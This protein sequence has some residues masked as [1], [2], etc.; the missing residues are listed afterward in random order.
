MIRVG[1]ELPDG[2]EAATIVNAVVRSYMVVNGEYMRGRS[3]TQKTALTASLAQFGN[4]IKQ[5]TA[6][7]N[8]LYAKGSFDASKLERNPD[9]SKNELAPGQPAVSVVRLD[10]SPESV[11][12]LVQ[13]DR[14]YLE[15]VARLE[16]TNMLLSQS[17]D[18]AERKLKHRIAEEFQKVPEVVDIT[19]KLEHEQDQLE[20]IKG[21]AMILGGHLSDLKGQQRLNSLQQAYE[22][23]W[24]SKYQGIRERLIDEDDSLFSRTRIRELEIDV[25]TARR[26]KLACRQY[27]LEMEAKNRVQQEHAFEAEFLKLQVTALL[28]KQEVV[29]TQLEQIEFLAGQ[30][31]YRVDQIDKAVAPTNPT[32]SNRVNY[33]SIATLAALLLIVGHF[34]AHEIKAGRTAGSARHAVSM[35]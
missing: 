27:A 10:Q 1:L 2:K 21:V 5:K 25:E 33:V 15:A 13:S 16:A 6:E 11:A 8:V 26:M 28:K 18:E 30:E 32:T 12:L 7:L 14:Q 3:R 22:K 4:E 24:S 34:L 35:P 31:A 9:A 20:L 29:K 17:Q 19:A 23:L